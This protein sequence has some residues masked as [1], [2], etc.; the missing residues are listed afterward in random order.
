VTLSWK[1]AGDLVYGVGLTRDEMGASAYYRWLAEQQDKPDAYG[2]QVPRV[3]ATEALALYRAMEEALRRG[4]LRSSHTL[5]AGGLAVG[6]ALASMGGDLGA[7]IVLKAVPAASALND[8]TLL[9]SESNS[10]F[11]VSCAPEDRDELENLF[12]GL[13]LA[14]IGT[15][16]GDHLAVRGVRGGAR[17]NVTPSA[18]R[19]I[20][21]QTLDGI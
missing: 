14:Q 2:G 3:Y 8:D 5:S 10:R 1:A 16:G 13:P 21:K 20:Y 12:Q 11:L 9:F 18:M 15:V 17:L 19:K 7:D 4:L 6:L